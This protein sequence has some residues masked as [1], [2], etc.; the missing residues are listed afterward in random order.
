MFT[1]EF[2]VNEKL[3]IG[4]KIAKVSILICP[5]EREMLD[6]LDMEFAATNRKTTLNIIQ[7]NLFSFDVLSLPV[8]SFTIAKN[9]FIY[10]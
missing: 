4:R 3:T 5:N 1:L 10:K 6:K 7:V 2:T 8:V 9:F